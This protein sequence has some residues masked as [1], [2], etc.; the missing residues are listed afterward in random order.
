MNHIQ[1]AIREIDELRAMAK[2]I[3]NNC[4]RVRQELAQFSEPVPAGKKKSGLSDEQAAT[5]RANFK[6]RLLKPK[7]DA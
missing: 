2:L 6:R 1:K 7:T 3:I 5:F 4:S